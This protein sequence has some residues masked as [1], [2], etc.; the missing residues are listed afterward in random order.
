LELLFGARINYTNG[1]EFHAQDHEIMRKA[2]LGFCAGGLQGYATA[3]TTKPNVCIKSRGIGIHYDW[4]RNFMPA[5]LKII[6]C[7]RDLKSVFA[8]MEKIFRKGQGYLSQDIQN[9]ASMR[10]T[11]TFKRVVDWS[12]SAPVGLALE[13]FY[14]MIQ[15]KTIYHCHIVR[16]EDLTTDPE[17]TMQEAYTYLNLPAFQHNFSFVPQTTVEDDGIHGMPDLH[18]IRNKVSPLKDDSEEILGRAVCDWI[19][20][21]FRWY[22]TFFYPEKE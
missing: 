8:S 14:Q 19:D 11:T 2:W 20:T 17:Q 4:Y 16:A 3:L 5:P 21:N 18:T 13:R 10:G 12:N 15:E 22:K 6:C 9:H 1:K 7:V